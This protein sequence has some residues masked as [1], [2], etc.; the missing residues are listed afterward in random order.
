MGTQAAVAP[1]F[2]IASCF[3]AASLAVAFDTPANTAPRTMPAPP[4]A[5]PV[6]IT[7]IGVR[8]GERGLAARRLR[9]R[10]GPGLEA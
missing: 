4:S 3:V 5:A 7:G 1:F 9:C 8:R 10:F 2:R 6:I